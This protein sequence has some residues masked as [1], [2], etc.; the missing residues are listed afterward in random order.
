[1]GYFISGYNLKIAANLWSHHV[2]ANVIPPTD[3]KWTPT[4]LYRNY[5]GFEIEILK[6]LSGKLNFSYTI[7]NPPEALWGH[8]MP[9]GTW[10]GLVNLIAKNIVD[11]IIC[12]IVYVYKRMQVID[13][14]VPF[15]KD[16]LAVCAPLPQLLP[17]IM[18]LLYPF[19][20][21]VWILIAISLVVVSVVFYVASNLEGV[22]TKQ[23]FNEWSTLQNAIWYAY[24]TLMGEAITRDTRSEKALALRYGHLSQ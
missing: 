1:M 22:L 3:P 12:D 13:G 23:S 9:D 18:A 15:E 8:I 16:G 21:F 20:L 14:L 6:A 7:E 24:G 10:D 19:S 17:K 5:W 2:L 4:N 11:L